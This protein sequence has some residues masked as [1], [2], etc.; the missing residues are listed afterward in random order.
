[1]RDVKPRTNES[2]LRGFLPRFVRRLGRS[3]ATLGV[4][5]TSHTAVRRERAPA[6]SKRR[7][8]DI[9]LALV[10]LGVTFGNAT[11]FLDTGPYTDSLDALNVTLAALAS[12]PL[13]AV[14]RNPLA[15]F[16]VTAVA[17][18]ALS[19]DAK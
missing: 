14:R 3:G 10:V 7:G 17:T 16:V 4:E 13:L 18:A 9:V 8:L 5:V 6:V 2:T 15:V 11:G 12:L 19:A 1:M